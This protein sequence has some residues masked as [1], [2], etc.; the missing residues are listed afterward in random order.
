MLN[1]NPQSNGDLRVTQSANKVVVQ[2]RSASASVVFDL[3]K[4]RGKTIY[5]YK[6]PK[7]PGSAMRPRK[8]FRKLAEATDFAGALLQGQLGNEVFARLTSEQLR[9]LTL[10]AE[11][12]KPFCAKLNIGLSQAIHEYIQAKE[13]SPARLLSDLMGEY[14]EQPWVTNSRMPFSTAV[15]AF[16][17][18]RR[19][20]G[21]RPETIRTLKYAMTPFIKQIKDAAVGDVTTLQLNQRIHRPNRH[22]RSNKTVYCGLHNLFGWLKRNGYYRLNVW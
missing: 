18:S 7:K 2:N 21:C 8:T 3:G 19:N 1:L 12:L 9:E 20:K 6:L 22:S 17:E 11:T 14:L 5:I 4:N 15:E 13:L 16:L 10:I